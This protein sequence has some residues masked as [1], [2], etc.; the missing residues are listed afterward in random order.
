MVSAELVGRLVI[1]KLGGVV[2][3]EILIGAAVGVL[4]GVDVM[5]LRGV[6]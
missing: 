1:V 4:K 3:G 5:V 6:E 2:E